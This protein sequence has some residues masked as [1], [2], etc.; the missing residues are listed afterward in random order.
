[1]QDDTVPIYEQLENEPDKWYERFVCYRDMP[2]RSLIGTYF[3]YWSKN[4]IK[5]EEDII[6]A[7]RDAAKTYD[8]QFRAELYDQ[9]NNR[10]VNHEENNTDWRLDAAT[11]G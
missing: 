9:H 3:L 2:D 8:W 1:M 6:Q 7:W 4:P 11:S 10:K 5:D